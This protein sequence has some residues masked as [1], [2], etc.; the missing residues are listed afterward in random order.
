MNAALNICQ[1]MHDAQ[2]PPMVSES[3]QEVARAEWL[4]NATEQLVRFGGNVAFQGRARPAK[5]VTSHQF[6][7]AVDEHVNG[8]LEDCEIVT[9]SLGY[10]VI[11]AM[12]GRYDKAAAAEL[13]GPSDH[14]LGVLGEIAEGLLRPLV[15][16]ALIAQAEDEEL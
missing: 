11:A 13:L 4:Y 1:A 7:M 5:A 15:G 9:A 10:L 3:S 16:D 14:P 6:A 12:S 8:R 2:L